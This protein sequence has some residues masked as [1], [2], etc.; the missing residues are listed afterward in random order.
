MRNRQQ[1]R[2]RGTL[3]PESFSWLLRDLIAGAGETAT[4]VA[5]RVP[6]HPSLI[7]RIESMDRV[8]QR[9]FAERCDAILDTGGRLARA[10]DEVAWYAEVEHPDWFRRYAA[11]EAEATLLREYQMTLIS[12]L[13]QTP[14]YAAALFRAQD[15][16]ADDSVIAERVAARLSRQHRFLSSDNPPSLVVVLDEAAIR[17]VVGGPQVMHRQLAHLLRVARRPNIIVQVAPFSLGERT[18]STS[19]FTLVT[20][21]DATQWLYTE[22]IGK[23]HFSRDPVQLAERSGVYD[24]LSADALSPRESALLIRRAMEGFLNMSPQPTGRSTPRWFKS[25]YSGGD[26]GQ[27]VEV[28]YNLGDTVPV[29]DSK[30]PD[31]PALHFPTTTWAR[32]VHATA[33]GE[34]GEA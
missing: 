2:S 20:L 6:C 14:E 5:R 15:E 33:T 19:T 7:S 12:G 17:R 8:P 25:S 16:D 3:R 13:L 9:D 26:G 31:G 4:S 23:G 27:C 28:A 18:R 22:S 34:F 1:V 21:E 32:F 30:N 10:W 11:M 29:R 24:R